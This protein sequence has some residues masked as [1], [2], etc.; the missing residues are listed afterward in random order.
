MTTGGLLKVE[1]QTHGK[2]R[3]RQDEAE[4]N[5]VIAQTLQPAS[6]LRFTII[7]RLCLAGM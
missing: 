6:L 5:S 4:T 2:G 1:N 7:Q 3:S